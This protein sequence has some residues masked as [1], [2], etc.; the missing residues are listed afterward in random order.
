MKMIK[1][2]KQ[3]KRHK[4]Q[5]QKPP[6]S[7]KQKL[8]SR[9]N[10]LSVKFPIRMGDFVT[11]ISLK[12]NICSLWLIMVIPQR[13]SNSIIDMVTE[14]KLHRGLILD[15]CHQSLNEWDEDTARGFSDFI[16]HRMVEEILD[17]ED[18]I[19]YKRI[20]DGI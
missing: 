8:Q 13:T 11:S 19:E 9:R 17:S 14:N 10:S 18:Y 4:R 1:R 6:K 16:T 2:Q 5:K 20:H 12:K 7:P 3:H 15:F